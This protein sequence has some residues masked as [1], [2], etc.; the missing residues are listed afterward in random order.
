[1][2]ELFSNLTKLSLEEKKGSSSN[3][4]EI[5]FKETPSPRFIVKRKIDS[6]YEGG[7][8][9]RYTATVY[10]KQAF[11]SFYRENIACLNVN[12]YFSQQEKDTCLILNEYLKTHSI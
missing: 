8:I 5:T 10:Y 4:T 1:M 6:S 7:G 12:K 11:S 2:S 3:V 9:V